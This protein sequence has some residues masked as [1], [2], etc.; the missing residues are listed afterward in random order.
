MAAL[1]SV[2]ALLL[3]TPSKLLHVVSVVPIA[4]AF[5]LSGP[6]LTATIQ[7]YVVKKFHSTALSVVGLLQYGVYGVASLYVG[8][9]IDLWGTTTTRQMLCAETLVVT[10]LIGAYYLFNKHMDVIVTAK[11]T[12][13]VGEGGMSSEA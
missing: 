8:F 2:T 3:V 5:G 9:A 13:T 7:R 10:V 12:G 4:F 1:A 11:E 6:P